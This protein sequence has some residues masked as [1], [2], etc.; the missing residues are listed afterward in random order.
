M[1]NLKKGGGSFK[2]LIGECM[3]KLTNKNVV[4]TRFFNKNKYF[5]IFSKYFNQEQLGFL[6]QNWFSIDAIDL[7]FVD[8]KK[9]IILYE[10]KTR[11]KYRKELYFKPKMTLETH[12]VY[13][14][15]KSLDF[16]TKIATVWLYDNWDYDVEIKDFNERDY[17]IDKPKLYDK[18]ARD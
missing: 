7:I 14:Q 3:F 17:Y 4:I 11:N 18:G 1:Y 6:Q 2:G 10:I 15:A 8:G 9:Q 5:S 16:S 12:N 13:N